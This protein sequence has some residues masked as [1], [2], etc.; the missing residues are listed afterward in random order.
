VYASLPVIGDFVD[1]PFA[2]G[3]FVDAA[4]AGLEGADSDFFLKTR[5]KKGVPLLSAS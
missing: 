2:D 3:P 1:G 5:S 4:L